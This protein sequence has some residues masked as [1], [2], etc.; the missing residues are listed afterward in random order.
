MLISKGDRAWQ[1]TTVRRDAR[2]QGCGSEGS[3]VSEETERIIKFFR[4]CGMEREKTGQELEGVEDCLG[5]VLSFILMRDIRGE[6]GKMA[7]ECC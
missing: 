1:S 3:K 2:P 7:G 5:F 4:K 6:H